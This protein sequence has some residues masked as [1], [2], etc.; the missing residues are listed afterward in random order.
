[1]K[2]KIK[3]KTVSPDGESLFG[4]DGEY[5]VNDGLRTVEYLYGGD[6]CKIIIRRGS[7][8]QLHGGNT[9]LNIT[10]AEGKTT[11]CAFSEGGLSGGYKIFTR[12]LT[13]SERAGAISVRVL[14]RLA[15]DSSPYT[16]VTVCVIPVK[17]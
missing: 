17:F 13:F 10:F 4:G 5:T 3:I 7:L 16:E 1:M 2:C 14:Y 8:T 12:K 6:P 11:E 9:N 15:D